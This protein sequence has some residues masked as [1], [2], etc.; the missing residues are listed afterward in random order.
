MKVA[1][2]IKNALFAESL[3]EVLEKLGFFVV[4]GSCA[5]VILSD[6]LSI[7]EA[8]SR[9]GKAKLVLIDLGLSDEQVVGLII[10]YELS[11]VFSPSFTVSTL[12]KALAAIS[13]GELW[14]RNC[15]VKEVIGR[16]HPSSESG[17]TVRERDVARCICEGMS[18][19]EIADKLLISEKT[20]KS[21][22]NRIFKKLN[23]TS[24][25]QLILLVVDGKLQL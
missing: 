5:D 7:E 11:G 18:N 1:L 9:R 3:R 8:H 22:L 24:R 10:S 25:A 2:F 13:R 15:H 14:L 4:E 21:H 19:R 12:K 17:L 6:H 16:L 23:I 20:V